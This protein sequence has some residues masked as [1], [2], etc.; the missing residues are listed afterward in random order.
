MS[1]LGS[2]CALRSRLSTGQ[3]RPGRF[4]VLVN[5][6]LRDRERARRELRGRA[7]IPLGGGPSAR[8]AGRC[9]SAPEIGTHTGTHLSR[10]HV[11]SAAPTR[12]RVIQHPTDGA[13]SVSK[14][15]GCRFESCRPCTTKPPRQQ[16]FRPLSDGC[17]RRW[18]TTR[19]GRETLR[20]RV[21]PGRGRCG[22]AGRH[23]YS[24]EQRRSSDCGTGDAFCASCVQCLGRAVESLF[25]C[26]AACDPGVGLATHLVAP[27]L[28]TY[29]SHDRLAR[30]GSSSAGSATNQIDAA[31]SPI[32]RI[33]SGSTGL[34]SLERSFAT[35]TPR[36]ACACLAADT[37][38]DSARPGGRHV[39]RLGET[40]ARRV[41]TARGQ[42]GP[43]LAGTP[44]R[45]SG[46]RASGRRCLTNACKGAYQQTWDSVYA[47][48][49]QGRPPRSTWC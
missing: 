6:R 36:R 30:G 45:P 40:D 48:R 11:T 32:T 1:S 8:S 24:G 28:R 38:E 42:V 18:I 27:D 34:G 3:G 29:T 2:S 33:R 44:I 12:I 19:R 47:R 15:E 17:R 39:P 43:P 46:G 7:A 21:A 35:G 37:V 4:V 20:K 31:A 26:D 13:G 16:G 5:D 41:D 49:N 14:T 22:S 23:A 9:S 10:S 25:F